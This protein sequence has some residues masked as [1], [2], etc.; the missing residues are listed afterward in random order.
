M[1]HAYGKNQGIATEF[2]LREVKI[3]ERFRDHPSNTER[4]EIRKI[5]KKS[6]RQFNFLTLR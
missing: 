4:L 6:S 2:L 1:R 5:S 3:R